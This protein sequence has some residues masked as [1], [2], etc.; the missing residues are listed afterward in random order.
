MYHGE[1]IYLP[2][3]QATTADCSILELHDHIP[4]RILTNIVIKTYGLSTQSCDQNKE[5]KKEQILS[6]I[7]LK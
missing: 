6:L 1:T 4:Y 3:I 7:L 5:G 2:Q